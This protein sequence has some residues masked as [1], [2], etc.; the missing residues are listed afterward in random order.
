[1]VELE[2][3]V[4]EFMISSLEGVYTPPI[5]MDC[6]ENKGVA[7]RAFCKWLKRK[8]MDDSKKGQMRREMEGTARKRRSARVR[9]INHDPY[10]HELYCLSNNIIVLVFR[11][12]TYLFE[13][14]CKTK[15]T[16]G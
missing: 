12:L 9:S 3:A 2:F 5:K 6:F 14:F 16:K 15:K 10:Y 8:R 13:R 11:K 7:G 1:M 4:V